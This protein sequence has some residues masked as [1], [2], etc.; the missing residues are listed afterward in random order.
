MDEKVETPQADQ[1]EINPELS[2]A[3]DATQEFYDVDEL[4]KEMQ[5]MLSKFT[6]EDLEFDSGQYH[7]FLDSLGSVEDA[8][9]FFGLE[10]TAEE[11]L[12]AA[13][14]KK[15]GEVAGILNMETGLPGS[16]FFDL[17][18]ESGE[19]ELLY[20]FEDS[21]LKTLEDMGIKI[22]TEAQDAAFSEI[23]A[24]LEAEGCYDIAERLHAVLF[25]EEQ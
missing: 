22:R 25:L 19:F 15:A 17:D 6:L 3:V 8:A 9:D 1:I 24:A 4:K 5:E 10:K 12:E 18:E 7:L 23:L 16:F 13:L 20:F 21:D 14:D 11:E 2:E